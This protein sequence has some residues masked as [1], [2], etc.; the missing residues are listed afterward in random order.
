[1]RKGWGRERRRKEGGR[2]QTWAGIEFKREEKIWR[3]KVNCGTARGRWQ[4]TGC[5]ICTIR[6]STMYVDETSGAAAVERRAMEQRSGDSLA[7]R[8]CGACV[9][10][11]ECCSAVNARIWRPF[12]HMRPLLQN[13]LTCKRSHY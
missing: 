10:K 5:R 2:R 11:F 6:S 7:D 12:L 8:G 4:A 9:V 1:M 13:L 3:K